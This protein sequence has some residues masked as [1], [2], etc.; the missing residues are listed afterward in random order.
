LHKKMGHSL[1]A[2]PLKEGLLLRDEG[3]DWLKATK[4]ALIMAL[5]RHLSSLP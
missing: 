2:A 1:A 3:A 4:L 5:R